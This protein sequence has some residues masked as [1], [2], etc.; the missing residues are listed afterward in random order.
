MASAVRVIALAATSTPLPSP[1]P[2]SSTSSSLALAFSRAAPSEVLT[3]SG[4]IVELL[5]RF[6]LINWICA[7]EKEDKQAGA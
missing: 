5:V 2:C 4:R 3:F 6:L 7:G 1:A